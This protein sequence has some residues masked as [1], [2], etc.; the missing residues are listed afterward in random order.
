M[1][2]RILGA[3]AATVAAIALSFFIEGLFPLGDWRWLLLVVPCFL[4]WWLAMSRRTEGTE[5]IRKE[6]GPIRLALAEYVVPIFA[7]G[8]G[9]IMFLMPAIIHKVFN[10]IERLLPE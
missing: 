7:V 4:I 5:S 8:L 6:P 10:L 2:R 9:F 3:A 1:A